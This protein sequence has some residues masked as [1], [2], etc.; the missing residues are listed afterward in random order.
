MSDAIHELYQKQVYPPMSHPLSDPAVSAVAAKIGGLEVPHP[1]RARILEIGCCSGHNL[2]PLAQRWPESHFTG[3]DLAE[4]SITEAR[5]RAAAVGLANIN[6]QAVDLMDFEPSDGPFDFIIA[7]G[8]F[9]WVPDEVKATLLL[10]CRKHLSPAGIATISFN[11]EC[12]W[13][14]RLP[15][16]AKVRAIQQAGGGNEVSALE[17]LKTITDP[18][19]PASAIIED[20]LDRGPS[21]LAFDDFGPVNDPWPLDRFVSAAGNAGLRWLGESDPGA[22]IPSELSDEFLLELRNQ[23]QD[24]LGFQAA[25]DEAL[26]R[27]FRSGVLCRDDAPVSG[28]V[29]LEKMLEFSLRAGTSPADPAAKEIFQAIRGFAPESISAKKWLALLPD[30]E[31]RSVAKLIFDGITRGWLRPRIEPVGY[32]AS[33]PEFPCLDAFRLLCAR[34]SLPVVDAW[35][36]P[37]A[38][39]ATH[40]EVLA[41]MEGR[42]SLWE[43]AEL[44]KLRCPDL[45]FEPWIA[46]LAERGLFS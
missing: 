24:P 43:L 38:F 36:Q 20:M 3:I 21:I 29:S 34:Q 17:I 44:S 9:S 7:H 16:I 10:F 26:G 4:R 11:L 1:Q 5:E 33:P 27:T 2:I 6:F 45:D 42:L 12:G 32:D 46:H 23:V 31:V 41:A 19:D 14:P 35:H 28:K 40:Y 15:V 25:V 39:P 22:N 13:K 18:S 30:H 8:F 37:C